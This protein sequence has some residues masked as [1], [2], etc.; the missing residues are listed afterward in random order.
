MLKYFLFHADLPHPQPGRAMYRK[1]PAGSGWPEHCPPIRAANAFGWDVINP[2][3][4][5]FTRDADGQ[6]ALDESNEVVSDIEFDDGSTPHDQ[7]NAWPWERGQQRPHKI[8]NHVYEQIQHQFKVST[9]LYLR[10]DPGQMLLLKAPPTHH[11]GT[12]RPWTVVEAI[13]EC[14]WYF[15]AHPWHGVIELPRID[16]SPIDE[17]IIP[18]GEPLFRLLPISRAAFHAA[19]MS[20]EDFADLFDESQD[21]LSAH[22]SQPEHGE[23]MLTGQFAKQQKLS[24]FTVEPLD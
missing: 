21:W 5:R 20:P 19:E 9:F 23:L 17:V 4:M 11:A 15:P 2:F 12:A 22:G 14:D 1:V 8:A 6:W 10:T 7:L 16:E 3:E 24:E 13:I 18:E